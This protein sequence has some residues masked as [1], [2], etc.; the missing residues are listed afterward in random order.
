MKGATKGGVRHQT[1]HRAPTKLLVV[2][3]HA[4]SAVPTPCIPGVPPA[5]P[6][7]TPSPT[8]PPAPRSG[9]GHRGQGVLRENGGCWKGGGRQSHGGRCC[10]RCRRRCGGGAHLGLH[11]G[12]QHTGHCLTA[13]ISGTTWSVGRGEEGVWGVQGGSRRGGGAAALG[14]WHTRL[15]TA[16]SRRPLLPCTI[17]SMWGPH[18]HTRQK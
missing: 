15:L 12:T 4:T 18:I 13:A 8:T 3:H 17:Q 11:H 9:D 7:S 1:P 10:C 16:R 2:V 14:T 6:T 5:V